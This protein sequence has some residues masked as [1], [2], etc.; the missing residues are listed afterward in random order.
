VALTIITEDVPYVSETK[1]LKVEGSERTWR[2]KRGAHRAT[3][4]RRHRPRD[5]HL[6]GV[7]A[8]DW[9]DH[10]PARPH[11]LSRRFEGIPKALLPVGW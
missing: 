6:S 7:G 5:V 3:G 11:R 10:R 2:W 4:Y 9:R 1:H 8:A